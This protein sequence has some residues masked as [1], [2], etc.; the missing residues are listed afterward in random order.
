MLR[1]KPLAKPNAPRCDGELSILRLKP[2]AQAI[3]LLMVTGSAH[4]A[5]AFS[6]SWFAAKGAAQSAGAARPGAAVPGMPPLAQQQKANQQLQRSLTN[7]NNTVAAIAAQQ[8]AQAAGRQAAFG[9]VQTV[10]DGLGE[11]GLQVDNSLTQGWANAQAPEQSQADGKT[12]VKIQQTADKAIL[13]WETFNVGRNTTV[14]FKQQSNWA[15][16]NRVNDP[17]ARPSQIQGQIK[18]D[19]TVMLIN[20]NGIVFSGT[21][22]VNVRNLVAAAATITDAQFNQGGLYVDATGSQP[23]FADAVGKVLV[24]RGALIETHKAASSTDAGGYTLLLGTEVENA[25][26]IVTAKGQ[27]TLAAGD[28]FY[29]RRGVGTSGNQRS[30]TRGNEVATA[31]KTG[32]S[33]GTVINNGL[34]QASTGDITLTGHQVQQNAVAVASTSVDIRG[35]VHLLNSATDNTGSVTLG[36]GSTTA[37]LLDA[38]SGSAL[39]S[40]RN[41]A[42]AGLDGLSN[43]LNIGRFNNLSAVADR[44]DQSRV[45]IV[46]GG[47]VDF[48]NGSITMATGGQVAVSAGRRSLVREGAVI[49]VSGAIGVKVAMESN[50]IKINVQGNEQRDASV[51]RDSGKLSNSD[52]WVDLR[53]LVQVAAGTNG[54]ATDRWYTAGGLLEVGGYLGT[55]NHSVGEWMAQGGTLTFT[56]NDVVTQQN[57]QLNLSGGTLDVQSGYVQQSWLKGPNGRLYELSRAPGDILYSGLYNGYEDHSERWGQTDYYYSPLIAPKQRYEQGYTVGRDA[58]KLVIATT[59]AVLEGQ[60]VGEVFKGERQTQAPISGLDGYRQSQTAVARRAQLLVGN[61][62]PIYD[63]TTGSLNSG[64]NPTLNQVLIG[65]VEQKIA[66]GLDLT[67]VVASD[68]QGTLRLDSD[69]LNGFQLGVVKVAARQ[70][71]QVDAPLSVA[72]GGEITLYAPHVSTNADLTAR[73]GSIRLGNVLKQVNVDSNFVVGDVILAPTSDFKA[74]VTVAEGVRLNTAGLWSNLL[75]DASDS[76]RLP[77]LNGGT[78]SLRSSGDIDLQAGSLIDVSSGGAVMADSKTRGGKGGDLTLAAG[79]SSQSG[80]ASLTLGA[81]LRGEGVTGGGTLKIQSHKVQIGEVDATVASD[82]LQLA[83]DFFNKGF[84]AYDITGNEGLIVADGAQVDVI[85]P[86]YRFG[87]DA[88]RTATGAE[89]A[90]ALEH[91]LPTLYQENPLK[92]VLTQRKGASLSLNAGTAQSTPADMATTALTL[93]QGSV[94]SVDPGQSIN[95]RSIGQLTA[96]GTLNAWGGQVSL[97]GLNVT[98]QAADAVNAI[99]HGRSIWLG[100]QALIDVA[101][102][103]ATAVDARGQGYGQVRNGGQ[104]VIGGQIDSKTGIA[105]ASDLFVVLREGSRLEASGARALLDIPGQGKTWVASHGG[106]IALGSNNGLYLDGSFNAKAGG[107]GA[108]GG[109]LSVALETPY[110]LKATVTDRVL[111]VRELILSQTHVPGTVQGSPEDAAGSLVYGRGQ[112]GVDQIQAGGFDNVALL[113]NGLLSVAGDVALT[114]GQSLNLYSRGIGLAKDAAA[115]SRVELNAPHVLLA[116]I[117][118]PVDPNKTVYVRPLLDATVSTANNQALFAVNADLLDVQGSISFSS[119]GTFGRADESAVTVEREGFDQI[120]LNSRGDLRFLAGIEGLGMPTGITTQLITPGDMT[121]RAAQLYPATGVGARVLAG[122]GWNAGAGTSVTLYDPTRTLVIG[123]T[124]SVTPDVPYSVFG[125]LQLGAGTIEQGGVVRAPL[126]LIEV[127]TVVNTSGAT[128]KV[129]LLPGSLTSVSGKG[130]TLPYGGT[131]DGQAYSYGGKNVALVGQGSVLNENGDLTVGVIL[132]GQSITAQEGAVLDLSGGGDLLGAGFISGRG[133]STDARYN[134][135]VQIGANGGFTL[136]GLATNPVYAI[137]PGNQSAYA[138]VAAEGGAVDPVIGR[139]VTIG[140]GVPGLAAGTYTL[141]PSTYALLPGAFRVE[142]NGLAGLGSVAGA[143]RM[144]NGSW[145]TAGTLSVAN[146]GLRDSIASQLILTSGDVLRRYSQYNETSY[147]QFAVANAARLGVPRAMLPVDAKTLKLALLKGAK[148]EAFSFNGTG[149]FDAAP[150]GY[151]GTVVALSAIPNVDLEIVGADQPA[152]PAFSGITLDADSLNALQATR[153]MVGRLPYVVYGQG[154][155]Y[156]NFT[157][158]GASSNITLRQGATL[159]APEVF[160]VTGN[161]NL[162]VE[163]GAMINTIGR[164][165]ASF[166]AR[167]GFIYQATNLLAASNG[168]LN[169]QLAPNTLSG[170]ISVGGCDS[171]CAGQTRLYSEGSLVAATGTTLELGDQVRYGTRHLTLAVGN[172]NVGSSQALTDA[173]TRNVL[174]A[175]LSLSQPVLER[176]LRGD[177]EY[178]APA[179]ETLELSAREALNFYGSASL[180]TYDAQTGRSRLS[181]LMLTTPAMY[182]AGGANDVATIRTSNLIWNGAKGVPG[183]VIA[184]G[185][186]TGSGRLEIQAERIEFGYGDF[187]QPNSVDSLDRLAL[188]FANVNLSASERI[189]ANHKGSLAVYQTQGAFDAQ[190]GFSYSGGNL[191]IVTPLMT[192]EAGSLN[193]TTAGGAI[194]VSGTANPAASAVGLG[195]ELSLSASRINLASAVVLPSGKLTLNATNDLTLTDGA[196]IDVAG[197]AIVFNDLTKYSSGGEVILQSRNGNILQNAGSRIDLS[198]RNNRAGQLSAVALGSAAGIVDLQGSILGSSSGEYDA[199]GTYMPYLAGEVE[200]QARRLGGSGNLSEQ[201]A[202]LNQRLNQGEVFGSRSFQLKQGDLVMGNDLKASNITVSLDNGSLWVNGM[203]DASGERVGNISLSAKNALTLGSG[204]LLDAHGRRLRVDSYG[205]IIDSPNRAM[206]DLTSREGV[207]TL[208]SGARIDLRHGTDVVVGSLPGQNDGRARGTLELNARRMGLSAADPVYGDIAIDASGHLDIQGS[209]SIA[210]NAIWQ[211]DDAQLGTDPAAS[212]RPYQV[213]DQGYLDGKHLQSTLFINAALANNDLMQRKLAGLNNARYADAFHLRPG[214]EIVSATAD[215]DLVVQG[216]LDLSGYRY[217]SVNPHTQLTSVYGSGESGSLTLRAGGDLSI[218]GSINDGFAPPPATQDDKGWVLLPGIDFTGGD[219]VVPGAGVTLADDTAFPAGTTLN[220][221]APIKGVTLAAGTRLPVAVILDQPLELPAGTVLA[222]AIRDGSG[223]VLFAAGTLLNQNLTLAAGSQLDAGSLLT[224]A[225]SLRT[226]T[227]PKGVPLPN[228]E[229]AGNAQANT[230]KLNGSLVLARGSLIPSGTYVK[231]PTGVDSVQLRPEVAGRQGGIWA[232]APMLADGSQSWSLRLVSGA[233]TTAADSRVVQANPAHGD[234]RLADSHYGMF[235]QALPPKAGF[236][237]TAQAAMELA[238]AGIIVKAGDPVDPAL[239]GDVAAF[240]TDTPTYCAPATAFVWTAQAAMELAD[241]GI[242]VNAGDPV[243]PGLVGDVAVFCADTPTYCMAS[244]KVDYELKPGSSRFSVIRTGT[245]DLELLS[246]GN[247]RMDSLFGVY[248]AGTSASPTFPGD[249]YNQP[250]A[251]GAN[252]TVLNDENGSYEKLVNGGADSVYRAWYPDGG[253]NLTLKVGGDLTG[254]ATT[255]VTSNFGRPNPT[256]WGHDSINVG[257][258]L[259]RQG[260][261]GVATGGAAQ[262]TAWWINFGSYTAAMTAGVAD[263]MVGF[264]GFGTLGGGDLNVQVGGD[265]GILNSLAGSTFNSNINPRSQGLVLAVGG[266]GRVTAEGSVQLTGGGDLDLRVSGAVNPASTIVDGHLNGAVIDLRGHAQLDSASMGSLNLHYG[267]VLNDQSPG[268]TRAYDVFRA[269]RGLA[270]GGL[271]LMPGDATFALSTP[272]DL[273]VQDVADPGRAPLMSGSAFTSGA[274]VQGLGL[275]WFTLWTE[276]T[277]IDLFAAGGNLTPYTQG[278]ETDLAVVYP[279]ILRAVAA[280]GSLYYGEASKLGTGGGVSNHRPALVLAPSASG[281]LQF[282]AGDS[283]YGGDLTV[284]QSSASGSAMAT[285]QRPAFLATVS[286][287]TVGSNLSETGNRYG[288]GSNIFPLFAFGADSA[289]GEGDANANPARFY[290]VNGDLL[291]VS[292]GRAIT[293]TTTTDSRFGQTW[294]EGGGPVWMMAGRDIVSSGTG[295]GG[296]VGGDTTLAYTHAG[297]LFI[298]NN[299]NDISIASAGRDILY[300][301]FNVAGPGTL[302][303]SAGRNLLMEDK[304][305]VTSI[306][307]VVPGDSRAGASIVMQAGVGA[308]GPDY[309]RFITPYLSSANL[310]ETG[311]GLASQDGKVAKTYETELV[312]WLAARYGFMG[313]PQQARS[314]YAALPAEQRRVFAREVYFAELKAGGR[315]YNEEGGLRQGSY[316]RGREAIAALF[317]EKDVA[318]NPI[319][320]KGDITMYGGAGVHTDFGGGIQMLTPGGGQIFGIEGTAPPSTAGVITQGEGDIQLYA[321]GSILLGQSRIM[322]TFGGSIMGWSA[323]GDINAGRGSKT[324]VVYT[325]PKRLYDTWGNVTLSPSVPS[326]GAGIATL[327]PIPEVAPGDIDLI[328]PLGTIDAG[329][330]GIRVSGNVNIAALTVVN[331][332]NI[333]TQGKSTGV[334]M[335]A[336]VNTGAITSASSAASSATQAAEDV[337]RQQQAAS[338]QNQASVFTVQ[339]LSFGSEQLAPTRDGASRAPEAGYNPNSPVQVLGAGALDE[340]ARQRLTE[341]ERG[342]LTL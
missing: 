21:S 267:S 152:T 189:T 266:T 201:F 190:K 252:G 16:L 90:T 245:G 312:S 321:K 188:G 332:A 217:A 109:N 44:T 80:S 295:L 342:S 256:D 33:A 335:T 233:D 149:K 30:T 85:A 47:S 154:G 51:N 78:V 185:A 2:L 237:W 331:A 181:N 72:D 168:L 221:D 176:L 128:T 204:A 133:G 315:E 206:I 250:K 338:R 218:Y 231:L 194:D 82:T 102:R 292:S 11:G 289:A 278:V 84:S 81:G 88:A 63:S 116:G 105:T 142:I 229:G 195:A 25:G 251:L 310:A 95:L 246:G 143:Q 225:A 135:L 160:L 269:T 141:M 326:T 322:T 197:R 187:A 291:A 287:G 166:D 46:S 8:A 113:S 235:G 45:E 340:S 162:V 150:G 199:G 55:Q 239:V 29:I 320:Y 34:I 137:V 27:T 120:E 249:P 123:R 74:Q 307:A 59:S 333:Q 274:G 68:R 103:A 7:L 71:V 223:N 91:W 108:A 285:P 110:Y 100:E 124:G 97:G 222:A 156:I 117:L 73:S 268:E 122:Y 165:A 308:G 119:K 328:A 147:A 99:G 337:A 317:P 86:A 314:F 242:I 260:N 14:D 261:G 319:T 24:E 96:N 302:E 244:G 70:Q 247:L 272:G 258:W 138:P 275:S 79:D 164:G 288:A 111:Q 276:R 202:A 209:R 77:Y 236:V 56:G 205:K 178:G 4:A 296:G 259:W 174:P 89:P 5:T 159:S 286:T 161:G 219:I 67:S 169:V 207:L 87:E 232:I 309:D 304:V 325:P 279:S 253:G 257:N 179:L 273:V 334:P 227:W 282:L 61:Y 127:G 19:G 216:D 293:F 129:E 50:S 64:L 69:Q 305:S 313:T 98:G 300:S 6:S 341:E 172:I 192:G 42:L 170:S 290:A 13:N 49:D 280:G 115:N 297:N 212:G 323:E 153:L 277:A 177:T 298:H 37:I 157:G 131:V 60:I 255:A 271:T 183:T 220:Y 10:P 106:S 17:S 196:L 210:L 22:Q 66:A 265:A 9:R 75:L 158:I 57:A 226:F 270:A 136:P 18:G 39:D 144:R 41:A 299:P 180:D 263:Q 234:L 193:R 198:A 38:A 43:T 228:V 23:T 130:L 283:I 230:L 186:G 20:R 240:C 301:N 175:G 241:A 52:V 238:D 101:A 171:L 163:Q 28:S 284:T 140:A 311:L 327:N 324:T 48:Q 146:T 92:G 40:Q 294:Y 191:N 76:T 318:G 264:T 316:V 148:E 329:E 83:A 173:A 211:Y 12:T 65:D 336:S 213:I 121:L 118:A 306:G 145:T 200:I 93:G 1:C 155:N 151:G 3:A 208:A 54:Y 31:L 215:G 139:Q 167:D 224:S 107:A 114:T 125:R 62:T 339:V 36:Q 26:S 281:E 303:L 15:V 53:E 248:T 126:G 35:T 94:I 203:V 330:A 243:D 262:P 58:G 104:I 214:V 132:G 184:G 112:L 182:G 134:P 32:S 254:N